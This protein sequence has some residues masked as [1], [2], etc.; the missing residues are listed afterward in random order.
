MK[1]LGSHVERVEKAEM[2]SGLLTDGSA[3]AAAVV[4]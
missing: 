4:H 1:E 3:F 2:V